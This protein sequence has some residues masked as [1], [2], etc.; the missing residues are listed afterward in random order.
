MT[1]SENTHCQLI[2]SN[3]VVSWQNYKLEEM[4]P[5]SILSRSTIRSVDQ[6]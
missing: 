1:V 6:V 2:A 4:R 3:A 5:S